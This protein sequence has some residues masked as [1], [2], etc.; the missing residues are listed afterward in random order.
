MSD[1]SSYHYLLVLIVPGL[2]H[3]VSESHGLLELV[4]R[5]VHQSP[6]TQHLVEGINFRLI[7]IMG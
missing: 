7:R 2:E 6:S 3:V 5:D 4:K 1:P